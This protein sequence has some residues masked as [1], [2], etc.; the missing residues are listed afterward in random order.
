MRTAQKVVKG[1]YRDSVSLM[2]LSSKVQ[3][4]DGIDQASAIMATDNNLDLAREAGLLI[5]DVQAGPNDVLILVQGADDVVDAGLA[6]AE[7]LLTEEP[8]Q[9][10][11]EGP[12][13]LPPRSIR[14][15]VDAAASDLALVSTPGEYA[16]AEA[17][18][19]LHLGLDVMIFS[20]NVTIEDEVMLKSYARDNGRLVMGPD[21]GTAIVNGVPLGFANVVRRGEIGL[22]AAAG[23]GL[24]QVTCLIDRWGA[25]VSQALGTGSHDLGAQVGGITM[26]AG[27]SAL[28]ADPATQVIVLI[29][30][31]PEPGVASA[32]LDRAAEAG[33]PVVVCFLGTDAQEAA[34]RGLAGARTLEEAAV[35]AVALATGTRPDTEVALAEMLARAGGFA[36][37]LAPGQRWIRGLFSG[38]TFCYE[39]SFLL[40][41][42]LGAVYSNAPASEE[43]RLADVWKSRQHTVV[44]LGDDVFTRG[45]PHPMIDYRLRGERLIEEVADPEVA[46]ILL[47]V[48][49]G[50]G[51]NA[52]PAAELVPVI[53]EAL[54]A[55]RAAQR[56]LVFVA[57]VC[58][59]PGD[60][61]S[62]GRQEEALREAGVILADSNAQ[63][64]RL[65]AAVAR[66]AAD[67]AGAPAAGGA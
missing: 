39:A 27:L 20:D 59:T 28:V 12:A 46:V 17:L 67:E 36:G 34:Q 11:G 7:R 19:A 47:D 52:D 61:Q 33:K 65:A 21:C 6:E 24:Q 62:L 49:L 26:L 30:K 1:L 10:E 53:G 13:A 66:A 14:M 45:R 63:A 57:S 4:F 15:A 35:H 55:A 40:G 25:G 5:G 16:A 9:A 51:S 8:G 50:F 3:A 60:P 54:S 64:V 2:Q 18:K 31:P 42:D 32:V 37:G 22:V 23:T 38:G 41:A 56:G 48:V 44:D 29:S 58:G 43:Y